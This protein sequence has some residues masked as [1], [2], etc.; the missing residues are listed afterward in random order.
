MQLY[1]RLLVRAATAQQTLWQKN[2]LCLHTS[3]ANQD[4]FLQ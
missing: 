1:A 4:E 3:Q 2:L